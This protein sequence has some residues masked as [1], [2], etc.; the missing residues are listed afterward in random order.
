[1]NAISESAICVSHSDRRQ[2][3]RAKTLEADLEQERNDGSHCALIYGHSIKWKFI[4]R[5]YVL[6]LSFQSAC[7][8]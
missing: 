6:R 7:L 8:A 1:M 4:Y 3:I 2:E 5:F